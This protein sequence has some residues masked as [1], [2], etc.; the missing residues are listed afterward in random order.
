MKE[1]RI[2]IIQYE[3][4]LNPAVEQSTKLTIQAHLKTF[5][6]MKQYLILRTTIGIKRSTPNKKNNNL[7]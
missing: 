3:L 2:V 7:F 1:L 4:P 5:W 6:T